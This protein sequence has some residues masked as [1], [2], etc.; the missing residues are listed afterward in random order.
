MPQEFKRKEQEIIETA[1]DVIQI[2]T[3]KLSDR[4]QARITLTLTLTLA[5]TLALQA[6]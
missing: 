4:V 2:F 3:S 6:L 5:L 1:E